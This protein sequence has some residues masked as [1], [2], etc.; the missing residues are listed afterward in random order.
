MWNAAW[1][2]DKAADGICLMVKL[3]DGTDW[4]ADDGRWVRT[5]DP[6]K[7]ETLTIR[8]SI[9]SPRYHGF[10]TKGKLEPC[11]DSQT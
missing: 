6:R 1:W 7:P 10:V 4:M 11:G 9:R 8:E 3:P 5:G 2:P